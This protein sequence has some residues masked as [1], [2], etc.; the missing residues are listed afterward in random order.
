[1]NIAILIPTLSGGGAERVASIIG[2]HYADKGNNVYYFLGDY[3]YRTKYQVKGTI[4][5]T[6][7]QN[8]FQ[9]SPTDLISLVRSACIMRGY[10]RKY[11]I[12]VSISFMEEFNFINVLSRGKEKVILRICT[13][14][15]QRP[16]LAGVIYDRHFIQ[17]VYNL[18][19]QV[20]VMTDHALCEMAEIYRVN[21][22]KIIKIPNPA[23]V[24][25]RSNTNKPWIYGDK[26]VICVGR[27]EDVKQQDIA[28][29]AFS[30]VVEQVKEARMLILGEGPRKRYLE[31]LIRKMR[32]Q[33]KVCLLGFQKDVTY[34]LEHSRVFLMTSK[35][36][37]FPNG[38]IEAMAAGL[39][40]VSIA[41]SGAPQEILGCMK[42][43]EDRA[44]MARYGI[45]TPFLLGCDSTDIR[46]KERILGN[47]MIK[48]LEDD[49]LCQHYAEMSNKRV[50][51][52]AYEKIMRKWDNL[53]GGIQ[54]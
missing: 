4:V 41:S 48:M 18:A 17:A 53:I 8:S 44:I 25:R 38:M 16:E 28:I 35:T 5:N 54:R 51:H 45:V 31:S 50:R 23:I 27:L 43:A 39:P 20:V 10:K 26:T 15:S 9:G 24:D 49:S 34:F 2:N 14:L 21:R 52:Y 33:D 47:A 36:E 29:R 40:V 11:R 3:R 1:M 6:G 46:E 19:D 12:D 13:I 22:K 7:I 42:Q 32:L 30:I 37:G